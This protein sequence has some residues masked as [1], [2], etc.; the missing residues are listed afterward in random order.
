MD[1]HMNSWF[2][3]PV[4]PADILNATRILKSKHSSGHD[5][6]PQSYLKIPQYTYMYISH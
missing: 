4:T 3:D 1:P 5:E 6:N 2:I